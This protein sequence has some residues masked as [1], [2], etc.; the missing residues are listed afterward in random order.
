[1]Y[2]HRR[3]GESLTRAEVGGSFLLLRDCGTDEDWRERGEEELRG[4]EGEAGGGR[5]RQCK[6]REKIEWLQFRSFALF[7]LSFGR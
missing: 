4:R 3:G 5:S 1:M 6:D 7:K 2:C